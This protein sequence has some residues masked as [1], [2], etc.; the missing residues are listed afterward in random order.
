MGVSLS[1]D[2]DLSDDS[3]NGGSDDGASDDGGSDDGGSD[4]GGG[5]FGAGSNTDFCQFNE[6][7]NS[8]IDD[9]DIFSGDPGDLEDAFG[10]VVDDIDR[11]VGLAPNAIKA[12]IAILAEG[13]NG[14]VEVMADYD[15]D[16]FAVPEDDPR[17]AA[18]D[19]P[20][21]EEAGNRVD[22]FCGIEDES[23]PTGDGFD[24]GGDDAEVPD[25]GLPDDETRAIVIQGLQSAFGWDADL[26]ACVVD[27][28]GL[29][30]PS[31]IDP[32]VFGDL[33][34]EVCGQSIL[35]LFGG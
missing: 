4:D 30:D 35:E 23:E 26:A 14:F 31:S 10:Q 9:V 25:L 15:Y 8:G 24:T 17:L 27:E 13:F 34:G 7:V 21:Y 32:S 18:L 12:D 11:A 16:L 22:A 1:G 33:S 28:L 6:Q 2:S 29:D 20:R 19:D 5:D 3:G